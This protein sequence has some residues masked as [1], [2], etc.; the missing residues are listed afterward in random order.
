VSKK[1]KSL[2]TRAI[3]YNIFKTINIGLNKL[4][5]KIFSGENG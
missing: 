5:A 4:K 3:K 2:L 1:E